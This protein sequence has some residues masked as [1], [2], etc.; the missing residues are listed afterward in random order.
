MADWILVD[1]GKSLSK[2]Q[3]KHADARRAMAG[4]ADGAADALFKRYAKAGSGGP[5]GRYRIR[6][7][8]VQS[9]D[10]YL[11]LIGYLDGMSIVKRIEPVQ[12]M[13]GELELDL[14]LATGL[15]NFSRFVDRAGVL[16]SISGSDSTEDDDEEASAPAPRT[17]TFRLGG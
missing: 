6:V 16:S 14:E 10:D 15:R 17:A 12:A 1:K 11:R 3:T 5:P 2:W 7:R 13:P 9:A 8:G 4:G